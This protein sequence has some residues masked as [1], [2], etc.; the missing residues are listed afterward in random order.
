MLP[1][2]EVHINKFIIAIS[3]LSA[4]PQIS[5]T[6]QLYINLVILCML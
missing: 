1:A 2:Q 5:F 4:I 3:C 6:K